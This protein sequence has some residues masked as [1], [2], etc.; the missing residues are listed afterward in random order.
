MLSQTEQIN[1]Q[2][3]DIDLADGEQIARLINQEDAKIAAAIAEILPQIGQAIEQIT[4]R[5]QK[6]GRMAYFGSGTSGRIGILD[7]AEMQPTFSVAEDLIS[8][9]I[10]GG[11]AALRHA[12]ENAEDKIACADEDF[13]HFN[14]QPNDVVVAISAS[15]NPEYTLRVLQRARERGVMTVA[16]TSNPNAKF[17]PYAD[18][19]LNPI[20]GPEVIAGS[21]R[22]KSGTAQKMIL[23]MLSTGVMI[24][25]GK[26][27]HNYM[28]DLYVSNLKL[29]ERAMRLVSEICQTDAETARKVLQKAG[30]VK[31]ACVMLKRQCDKETA[32]KILAEHGGILRKIIE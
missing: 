23:N 4:A 29:R 13:E 6:G 17:K 5:L 10:S 24:R 11:E 7:A 25:M 27:Y 15:G 22:M 12:V 1:P 18:I 3:W 9:Y 14:P 28:V 21:S 20:L 31:T 16:L 30:N 26:T 8:G 19:F 2:T 32:E